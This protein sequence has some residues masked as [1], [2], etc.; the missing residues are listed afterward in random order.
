MDAG[1]SDF[2]IWVFAPAPRVQNLRWA[3][4]SVGMDKTLEAYVKSQLDCHYVVLIIVARYSL[5]LCETTD[6]IASFLSHVISTKFKAISKVTSV[7]PHPGPCMKW[8]NWR[9]WLYVLTDLSLSRKHKDLLGRAD[10]LIEGGDIAS[11]PT[12]TCMDRYPNSRPWVT[13]CRTQCSSNV[14][15]LGKFPGVACMRLRCLF[16]LRSTRE[17]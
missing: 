10:L 17:I 2:R 4:V 11:V 14:T 8:S 15:L 3:T 9:P 16:R 12:D 6:W 7:L 13:S 5:Q 1:Q